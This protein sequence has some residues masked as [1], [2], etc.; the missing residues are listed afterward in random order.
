[1]FSFKIF[2]TYSLF[3]LY[4]NFLSKCLNANNMEIINNY[5]TIKSVYISWGIYF[6]WIIKINVLVV[7]AFE[8]LLGANGQNLFFKLTI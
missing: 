6:R 4:F 8:A 7:V 2:T 1:M 3:Q 5:E